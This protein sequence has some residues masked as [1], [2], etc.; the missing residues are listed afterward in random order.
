MQ[1]N[2]RK[3]QWD[4]QTKKQTNANIIR[5]VNPVPVTLYSSVTLKVKIAVLNCKKCYQC[6]KVHNSPSYLVLHTC[7][8]HSQIW[9]SSPELDWGLAWAKKMDLGSALPLEAPE[10]YTLTSMQ[11]MSA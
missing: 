10:I 2:K 7:S 5:I 8:R 9:H 6:L 11:Y 1:T 4:K 3:K